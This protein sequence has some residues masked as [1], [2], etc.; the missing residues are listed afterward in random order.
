[1]KFDEMKIHLSSFRKTLVAAEKTHTAHDEEI[2][3]YESDLLEVERLRR[4]YEEKLQDESQHTGRNL[5][6]EEDQ[7]R[8]FSIE[9]HRF[10]HRR[11]VLDERVSS[12]ER[13][14]C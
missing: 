11:I 3:K 10:L 1:M 2:A 14:G 4:E 12:F 6:L 13:D 9:F 8:R 5:A 7:V